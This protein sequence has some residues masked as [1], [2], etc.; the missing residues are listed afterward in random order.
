MRTRQLAARPSGI[1]GI[2]VFLIALC[3]FLG[4]VVSFY[5]AGSSFDGFKGLVES[6]SFED[7]SF[8]A[9][10]K[11]AIL[12]D[13]LYCMSVAV[14]SSGFPI[15]F[16]PGVIILAKSFTVGIMAGLAAGCCG[17]LKAS[18]IFFSAFISNVLTLPLYVLLF[19]LTLKYSLSMLEG[20]HS[21]AGSTAA[22]LRFVFKVCI[23][24]VILCI[25]ECVQIGIGVMALRLF[26]I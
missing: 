13:L 15:S 19:A 24:F 17:A 5:T 21:P 3:V 20:G 22:Y 26:W 4:V 25:A 18:G 2:C 12:T 11:R 8:G 6:I 9:S 1:V 10:V 14:F 7:T 23:F 16:L